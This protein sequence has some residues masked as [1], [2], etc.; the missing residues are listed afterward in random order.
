MD[1]LKKILG[2]VWILL[3]LFVGYFNMIEMGISK[4]SSG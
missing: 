1:G 2:T 4:L 3:A